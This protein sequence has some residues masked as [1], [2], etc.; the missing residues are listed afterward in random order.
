MPLLN[1]PLSINAELLYALAKMG[2]GD[3]LIIAD[4][5]FPSDSVANSCVVKV[6]IRV[7]GKTA[8]F[9]RDMLKL[10]PLDQYLPKA[11]GVM[12]RVQSDKDRNLQ[13]PTYGE[14]ANACSYPSLDRLEFIERFEFYE[15][16]KKAF[17]IVQTDDNS[18]YANI[19]SRILMRS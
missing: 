10:L 17:V 14:V 4:A 3:V 1:V 6:P 7:N 19:L 13:V 9:L 11:V 16:A 12:D 18:L 15:R 8:D 2:H 5:N